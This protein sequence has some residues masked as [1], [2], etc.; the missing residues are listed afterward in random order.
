MLLVNDCAPALE[1][2]H[3]TTAQ[4]AQAERPLRLSAFAPRY[5]ALYPS[6]LSL[7]FWSTLRPRP[8]GSLPT[9]LPATAEKDQFS[10]FIFAFAADT[11]ARTCG[12]KSTSQ[13]SRHGAEHRCG[14]VLATGAKLRIIAA[15]ANASRLVLASNNRQDI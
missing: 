3:R 15:V 14:R 13:A 6:L 10:Y 11:G 1:V 2:I 7:C 9:L 8:A 5:I 12:L 4:A